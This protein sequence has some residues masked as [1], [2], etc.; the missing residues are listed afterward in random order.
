MQ[1]KAFKILNSYYQQ[2]LLHLTIG[3]PVCQLISKL[4]TNLYLDLVAWWPSSVVTLGVKVTK[5][6][7]MQ[8]R[9]GG[10]GFVGGEH[11]KAVP[12][13]KGWSVGGNAGPVVWKQQHNMQQ[14]QQQKMKQ[15]KMSGNNKER[16]MPWKIKKK[17][18]FLTLWCPSTGK[19][20]SFSPLD[21]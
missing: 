11:V 20:Y 18:H 5:C 8:G 3:M 21:N 16:N 19:Q 4:W 7:H 12:S 17:N 9:I 2:T 10:V 14:K 1:F 15:R 6:V 13:H